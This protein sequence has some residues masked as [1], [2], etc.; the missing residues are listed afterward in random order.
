MGATLASDHSRDF[1]LWRSAL[2]GAFLAAMLC[3]IFWA[4]AA[5]QALPAYAPGWIRTFQPA[6]GMARLVEGIFWTGLGGAAVLVLLAA[7][8]NFLRRPP[9]KQSA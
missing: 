6:A 4:T 8:S 5:A 1:S 2:V 3:L 7:V 9:D